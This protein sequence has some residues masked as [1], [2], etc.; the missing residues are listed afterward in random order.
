[1]KTTCNGDRYLL[2]FQDWYYNHSAW[3]DTPTS[4]FQTMYVGSTYWVAMDNDD[5]LVGFSLPPVTFRLA[6]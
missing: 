2:D 5:E 3:I 4:G 6:P 1:M